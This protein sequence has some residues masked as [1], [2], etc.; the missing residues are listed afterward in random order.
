[1]VQLR[2]SGRRTKVRVSGLLL[3]AFMPEPQRS[4]VLGLLEPPSHV[5]Q[6][7]V[8]PCENQK[9]DCATLQMPEETLTQLQPGKAWCP[10]NRR[11]IT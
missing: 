11:G 3:V 8:H 2:F 10:G 7:I 1:M 5:L 9:H 6:P 4:T